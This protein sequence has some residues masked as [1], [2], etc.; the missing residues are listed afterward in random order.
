MYSNT[1]YRPNIIKC[2][3]RSSSA[4]RPRWAVSSSTALTAESTTRPLM[5]A[6][7]VIA[8][9]AK[10]GKPVCGSTSKVK[11]CCRCLIFIPSSRYRTHS[12]HLFVTTAPSFTSSCS[13]APVPRFCSSQAIALE[14]RLESRPCCIP[15]ASNSPITIICTAL[16]SVVPLMRTPQN[17]HPPIPT[18]VSQLKPCRRFFEPNTGMDSGSSSMQEG[19][20][21]AGRTPHALIAE[22]SEN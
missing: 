3:A 15:G 8:L 10:A 7:T 20:T 11:H 19:S 12:I 9:D 16:S 14:V 21:S 2:S 22:G 5:A 17:G 18:S 1:S 6:A 13:I 4:A